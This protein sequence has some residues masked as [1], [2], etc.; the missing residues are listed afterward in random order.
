MQLNF[1]AVQPQKLKSVQVI[2]N[3][4]AVIGFRKTQQD[5]LGSPNAGNI[6]KLCTESAVARLNKVAG[7]N[8]DSP[9]A[10]S[11]DARRWKL[12]CR[13]FRLGRRQLPHHH[14]NQQFASW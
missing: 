4:D 7:A 8:H 12:D 11:S 5:R 2:F 1:H 6:Y 14:S 10:S 9:C 13:E 3:I